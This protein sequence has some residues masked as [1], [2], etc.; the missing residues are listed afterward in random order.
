MI[1][2]RAVNF[3]ET[4]LLSDRQLQFWDSKQ[5]HEHQPGE[6]AVLDLEAYKNVHIS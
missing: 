1:D 2:T 6:T 5:H 4:C 3:H